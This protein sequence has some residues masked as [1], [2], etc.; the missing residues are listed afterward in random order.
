MLQNE[1]KKNN[2]VSKALENIMIGVG[3]IFVVFILLLSALTVY[4]CFSSLGERVMAATAMLCSVLVAC[5]WRHAVPFLP[6]IAS[7][8]K[9]WAAGLA[10]IA[11]GFA[12]AS[13]FCGLLL[14]HFETNADH[15][16]PAIGFW[17]VF[18]IAIFC[19]LGIALLL[20]EQEREIF[21]MTR[22]AGKRPASV[23]S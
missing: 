7:T 6:V 20:S 1:F 16:I 19:C 4:L 9:R 5:G 15:Q 8:R 3:A 2:G 23:N 11:G 17:A 21:G 22:S 18:L 12:T 10:C 13:I 14:P